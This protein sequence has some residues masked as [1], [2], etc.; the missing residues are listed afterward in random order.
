VN[1]I[2]GRLVGVSLALDRWHFPHSPVTRL[3]GRVLPN[4]FM[5]RDTTRC[6]P[7]GEAEATAVASAR[8]V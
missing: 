4:Y 2:W 1:L 7:Y 3:H 6:R 8:R 5:N